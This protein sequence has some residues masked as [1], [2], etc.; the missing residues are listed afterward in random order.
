MTTQKT[1]AFIL[2]ET[3]FNA[4]LCAKSWTANE[5]RRLTLIQDLYEPEQS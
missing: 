2:G 1:L 3:I 5:M 4:D